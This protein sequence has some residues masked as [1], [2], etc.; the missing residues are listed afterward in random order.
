M[1]EKEIKILLLISIH[2]ITEIFA[3]N[4]LGYV[5]ISL[6]MENNYANININN[7]CRICLNKDLTMKS[8]L[9]ENFLTIFQEVTTLEVI[10][11]CFL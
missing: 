4:L 3:N 9:E 7:I 1:R 8:L 5:F 6:K 11:C 10:L 2:T